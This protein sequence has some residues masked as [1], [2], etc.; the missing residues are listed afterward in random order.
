M[1]HIDSDNLSRQL[2]A[3]RIAFGVVSCE[4]FVCS[5][6]QVRDGE[7]PFAIG[8]CRTAGLGSLES[9]LLCMDLRTDLKIYC[10]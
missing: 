2:I 5:G 9:R 7:S 1:L 10:R 3:D 4:Q 6:L 8:P